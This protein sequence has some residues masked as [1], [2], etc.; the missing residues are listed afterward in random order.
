MC[1]AKVEIF[2]VVGKGKSKLGHLQLQKWL[3]KQQITS[4]ACTTTLEKEKSAC[5]EGII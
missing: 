3:Y 4:Y 1:S 5:N 2:S